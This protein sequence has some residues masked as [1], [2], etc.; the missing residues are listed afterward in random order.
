LGFSL[1]LNLTNL[2]LFPA[3]IGLIEVVFEVVEFPIAMIA[4][5]GVYEGS[6]KRAREIE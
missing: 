6:E 4:G 3:K 5:A 1:F 2:G